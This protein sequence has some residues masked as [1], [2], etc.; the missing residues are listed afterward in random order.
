[1]VVKLNMPNLVPDEIEYIDNVVAQRTV[2]PNKTYFSDYSSRWKARVREYL[3]N[4]GNP[5]NIDDSLIISV[6]EQNKF[7]NLYESDNENLLHVPIIDELRNRELQFCPSCGE[8]GTPNTLDHYLP[9]RSFPEYSI[10]SINLFPMCDICQGK[11]KANTLSVDGEKLFIHPYYDDFITDQIIELVVSPPYNAPTNFRIEAKSSLSQSQKKLVNHQI[12][13]LS[14]HIRYS[15]FLK[16]EYI[17]LL[18]L[19]VIMRRKEFDVLAQIQS[20][21]D[22]AEMKSIN[23]WS[24]VFYAGVLSNDDLLHYL[25]SEELPDFL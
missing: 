4:F 16:D 2:N 14:L 21:H 1:M 22:M 18:K 15:K 13:E 5:E 3:D 10:L 11:K 25:I 20:F 9:K 17:R 6:A 23:T 24:Q 8:D 12:E 7:I 19:V